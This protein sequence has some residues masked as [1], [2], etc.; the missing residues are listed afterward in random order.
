[1]ASIE[2]LRLKLQGLKSREV[3]ADFRTPGLLE[4]SQAL[5]IIEAMS[6]AWS[7][8]A[9]LRAT[10]PT[11]KRSAVCRRSMSSGS[12]RVANPKDLPVENYDKVGTALNLRIARE[13]GLTIPQSLRLQA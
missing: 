12:C 2:E 4:T 9:P 6:R 3:D 10:I 1:M 8:M 7:L 5:L 11:T 13:I